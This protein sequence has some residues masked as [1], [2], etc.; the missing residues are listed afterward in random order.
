MS[1]ALSLT[2]RARAGRSDGPSA[3]AIMARMA[4]PSVNPDDLRARMRPMSGRDPHESGRVASSLELL[5][6]L[7]FVVAVAT[8]ASQLAD[9][10]GHGQVGA[11]VGAFC[12]TSFGIIWGWINYSWFASAYDTDDWLYRLLT[13][14][15]MIGVVIFTSASRSCSGLWSTAASTTRSSSS[16]TPSC[17][18]RCC[19]SGCGLP[20]MTLI[21]AV[22]SPLM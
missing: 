20:A 3:A 6:D 5:F 1:A 18:L 2:E 4:Y 17:G 15:Q 16:G 14:L 9:A 22:P 11:G 19:A 13:M 21:T 8:G 12:F 10:L 7:T